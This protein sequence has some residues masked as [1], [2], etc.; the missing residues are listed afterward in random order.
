MRNR[1]RRWTKNTKDTFWL[2][3]VWPL[4]VLVSAFAPDWSEVL[5]P[6]SD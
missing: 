3:C 1:I 6:H 5:G 2:L 4:V